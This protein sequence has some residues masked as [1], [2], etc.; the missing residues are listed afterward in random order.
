MSLQGEYGKNSF[1]KSLVPEKQSRN[2]GKSFEN[3]QNRLTIVYTHFKSCDQCFDKTS[4]DFSNIF[5]AMAKLCNGKIV[6]K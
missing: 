1:G 4:F 3:R 5:R 6:Q 2:I